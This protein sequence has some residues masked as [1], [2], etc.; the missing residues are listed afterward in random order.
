[1]TPLPNRS[2]DRPRIRRYAGVSANR[3]PDM[4]I[5][6]ACLCEGPTIFGAA[7]RMLTVGG[8]TQLAGPDPKIR[9]ITACITAL[10]AGDIDIQREILGTLEREIAAGE[11]TKPRSEWLVQEIVDLY[12]KHY[13]AIAVRQTEQDVL[14]PFGL[15][16]RK[17]LRRQQSL[18]ID[19]VMDVA[20]RIRQHDAP[21]ASVLIVGRDR[22]GHHLFVVND[23]VAT[24][25]DASGY[26]A[27]GIGARHAVAQ[28]TQ[29]RHGPLNPVSDSL[30]LTYL[31]K[32]R[33]EV[34]PGVGPETDLVIIA[35]RDATPLVPEAVE[36]CK[37]RFLAF[38]RAEQR[39]T[40][41]AQRAM[42]EWLA[43]FNQ[44]NPPKTTPPL[45][46]TPPAP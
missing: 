24:C 44:R 34:A 1:M 26:A 41:T 23:G 38:Q 20:G 2:F 36:A 9:N 11:A 5:C 40:T 43:A 21:D 19:F 15:T 35:D 37:T 3:D 33:A 25:R 10:I 42:R 31:A 45:A 46:P 4:T 39:A 7:D 12:V 13:T 29:W 30:F 32:K 8:V 6:V 16:M 18:A 28:F 14:A 17:Y 22:T 27:I